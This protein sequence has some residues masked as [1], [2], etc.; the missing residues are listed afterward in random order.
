MVEGTVAIIRRPDPLGSGSGEGA[1]C[2]QQSN[3][4]SLLG[5]SLLD[6]CHACYVRIYVRR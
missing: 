4:T 1:C 2:R 5:L 6:P 3:V